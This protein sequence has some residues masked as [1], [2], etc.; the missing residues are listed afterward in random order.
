MDL[1]RKSL[2]D[3]GQKL[4]WCPWATMSKERMPTKGNFKNSYPEGV[5][6][7]FTAGRSKLGDK[8]AESTIRY[9]KEHGFA[10]WCISRTGNVYQ[11]HPLN[12]W[13]SHAGSSEYNGR[14]SVSSF[15][16]GIEICNAGLVEPSGSVFKTWYGELLNPEEVRRTELIDFAQAGYYHKYS[17]EQEK[18]LIELILWLKGNNPHVFNLDLVVGHSEVAFPRGRK[19]DP[20]GALS[21]DMSKF[22]KVLQDEW[23][24]RKPKS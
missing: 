8:D 23:L 17:A 4:L 20:G 5:V 3:P 10:Y 7:H 13:G 11:T 15:L 1:E 21:Y 16:L 19:C 14:S 6:V 18:S 9:G 22:R 12:S 2:S 24:K